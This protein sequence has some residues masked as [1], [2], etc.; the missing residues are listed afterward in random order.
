MEAVRSPET[1]AMSYN[2]PPRG[3]ATYC[4]DFNC[5]TAKAK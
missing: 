2:V 3:I 4:E 5:T 1:S